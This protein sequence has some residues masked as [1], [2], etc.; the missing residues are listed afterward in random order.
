M[1]NL[2]K[3]LRVLVCGSRTWTDEQLIST[4]LHGLHDKFGIAAIIHGDCRGADDIASRSLHGVGI[5]RIA[6][7]PDWKKYGTPAGPIRN[8]KMIDEGKP[9]IVLA[10]AYDLWY[11]TGT[12]D[13]V[14]RSVRAKL[15]VYWFPYR[16]KIEREIGR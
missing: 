7:P 10:F 5:E 3:N 16:L 9:D 12:R 2:P 8:Q 11:S 13:M 6:F 1:T 4:T 15:P 14:N